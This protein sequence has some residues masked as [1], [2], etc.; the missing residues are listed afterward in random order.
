MSVPAGDSITF[1]TFGNRSHHVGIWYNIEGYY[2][3]SLPT[4]RVSL[5]T[6]I[7]GSQLATMNGVITSIDS[8]GYLNNCSSFASKVWNSI[9]TQ[10]VS[11]GLIPTPSTL[12]NSIKNYTYTTN[13]S[14]PP[15]S[16]SK[17][18]YYGTS[19]VYDPAGANDH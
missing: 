13:I 9:S 1:G 7:T 2:N 15:R 3:N 8:W 4:S 6:A 11:P 18:A 16:L 10:Q 5:T 12:S 17:I 19:L 14:I